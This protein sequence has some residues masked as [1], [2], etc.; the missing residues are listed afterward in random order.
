MAIH[1]KTKTATPVATA[2]KAL[3]KVRFTLGAAVLTAAATLALTATAWS[4]PPQSSASARERA[5]NFFYRVTRAL[6]RSEVPPPPRMPRSAYT[7]SSPASRQA[8]LPRPQPGT[9]TPPNSRVWDPNTQ[10]WV[11]PSTPV[12]MP[13]SY[14][15]PGA[16][17]VPAPQPAMPNVRLQSRPGGTAPVVTD[18]RYFSVRRG[19]TWYLDPAMTE[20]PS[21]PVETNPAPAATNPADAQQKP[22]AP[23]PAAQKPAQPQ[24]PARF[25]TPVPGKPGFAY[26]PGVEPD[27]K[28]MLDVRGLASGQ[29][30]RDPRS[31]LI[32]LVP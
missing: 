26:P 16:L 23:V 10:Q 25:G 19:E 7:T 30:V 20:D 18:P 29:K 9:T 27:T 4:R 8:A 22:A 17:N 24:A 13:P 6:E 1:Q 32:F 14:A 3:C 5:G 11:A 21:A 15:T 28:N 2:M 31:G 12:V